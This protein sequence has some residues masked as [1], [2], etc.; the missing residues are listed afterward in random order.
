MMKSNEQ[1]PDKKQKSEKTEKK[2]SQDLKRNEENVLLTLKALSDKEKEL[3][4]Q[5]DQLLGLEETLKKR[6]ISEIETK[7]STVSNLQAEIP[8]LKQRIEDLA[9][10][11]KIPVVKQSDN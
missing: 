11:L 4:A 7:K 1:I 8:E 6:I 5:R 3:L 2:V 9:K 10:V